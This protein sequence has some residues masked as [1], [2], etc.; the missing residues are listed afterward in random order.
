MYVFGTKW[1]TKSNTNHEFANCY[2]VAVIQ[3][4][5]NGINS[6]LHFC[7]FV[8][9]VSPWQH[10][11]ICSSLTSGSGCVNKKAK[12][13]HPTKQRWQNSSNRNNDEHSSYLQQICF[14]PD[15]SLVLL[16]VEAWASENSPQ[17]GQNVWIVSSTSAAF[18]CHEL[19]TSHL[20]H[21]PFPFDEIYLPNLVNLIRLLH[22]LQQNPDQQKALFEEPLPTS[23]FLLDNLLLLKAQ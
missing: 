23:A 7:T 22:R 3:N 12:Q 4:V 16:L 8:V 21:Q 20:L 9:P 11:L 15:H 19:A 18:N 17:L 14:K 6:S 5:M 10:L 1:K 2:I 13:N